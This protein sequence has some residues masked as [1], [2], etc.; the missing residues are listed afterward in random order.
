MNIPFQVP[1]SIAALAYTTP[2]P[3]A[4]KE[5][6]AGYLVPSSIYAL[7]GVEKVASQHLSYSVP[8]SIVAMMGMEKTAIPGLSSLFRGAKALFPLAALGRRA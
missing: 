8:S 1:S 4:E 6:T 7:V 5:V 3:P 2:P